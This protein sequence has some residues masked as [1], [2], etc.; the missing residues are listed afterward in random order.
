MKHYRF[1]LL[2]T[3]SIC[4]FSI[5]MVNGQEKLTL[6]EAISIALQNN[7]DIKL[8]KNEVEIAKNNANL[9]NAGILPIAA[10]TFNTGVA[11]KTLYKPKPVVPKDE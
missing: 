4:F 5:S 2:A 8:I 11:D 9:G 7:Y 10:A 1:G 6:K 3:L